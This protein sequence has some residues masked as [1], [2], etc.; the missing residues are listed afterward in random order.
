MRVAVT[1]SSGLIGQALC[2]HL[3]GSGHDVVKVVRRSL[4]SGEDAVQWDPETGTIDA[5]GLEGV[6]A[7]VNLSGAGIG[8]RRWTE[9]RKRVLIESRT[10]STALLARTLA[11]LDRK[12]SVLLNASAIGIYGE[13]GDEIVTEP[14]PPGTDFLSSLCQ[15]WESETAPAAEAGIR[16]VCARSGIVFTTEGGALPKLLPLFKLGLGGRFGSGAQWWS[17]ITL[18]DEIRALAWLLERDDTHGP[19]N[20]TAPNPVTNREF[21]RVMRTVLS[22]PAVLAVPRFG[23]KLLLGPELAESL[24][25]TSARVQPAVLEASGFSF[26]QPTLEGALQEILRPTAQQ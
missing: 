4:Q 14:D 5:A 24:L 19:V 7:V 11:G 3:A 8:D 26:S 18:D 13:R 25:F 17:W 16:V 10:R 12:P 21:T 1:G 2:S 22:R 15:R 9:A 20:L 23:P 6:D